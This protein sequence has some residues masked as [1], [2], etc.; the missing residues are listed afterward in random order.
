MEK[1]YDLIII[2]AGPAGLTAAIYAARKKVNTLVISKDVGGQAA[3]SGGIDNYLGFS[4]VEG[5]DL[6]RKFRE[7]I[8]ELKEDLTLLEGVEVLGLIKQ[9][10]N[11]VVSVNDNRNFL[12][13]T[14]IIASGR[15]P[16]MLGIPG[17]KEFLGKGVS[18]CATCDAPFAKGKTAA[19]IGGG[20]SAMDAALVLE[21]FAEKIY[22]VN[23]NQELRGDGILKNKIAS[24]EKIAVINSA[25]TTKILANSFVIGVE[26]IDKISN[27]TKSR[28]VEMVFIEIGYI[29][30]T[31]FDKLTEKDQ[32]GQIKVS[33]DL[34]TSVKGVW[35]AGDVN[36]LWGEQ[37]V[38]AA[39]EGSKAALKV[40][41]YLSYGKNSGTE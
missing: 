28:Q 32:W 12:S 27:Q 8:E 24:K 5:P 39:G 15:I 26:Y 38:I 18:T 10:D 7:H 14:V 23:I 2:G 37:I 19:V 30:S 25:Q 1:V 13:R 29:P 22:L 34:E 41:E 31:S 33:G 4:L 16:R 20:N 17:E 21:K 9:D 36:N 6:A 3:I 11:F 35:A 40:A